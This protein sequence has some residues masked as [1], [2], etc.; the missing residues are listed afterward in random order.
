MCLSPPLI[1]F[2]IPS[3]S[4]PVHSSSGLLLCLN[5]LYPFSPFFSLSFSVLSTSS[6]QS[7]LFQAPFL[8]L[9]SVFMLLPHKVLSHLYVPPS[10]SLSYPT[11]SFPLHTPIYLTFPLLSFPFPSFPTLPPYLSPPPTSDLQPYTP[12]SPSF[13][14]YLPPTLSR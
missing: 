7:F 13:L 2:S 14:P 8:F 10:L 5:L 9:P 4:S 11:P 1:P 12:L 3:L 6:F